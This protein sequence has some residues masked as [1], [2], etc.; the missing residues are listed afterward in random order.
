M[1]PQVTKVVRPASASS[2]QPNSAR[3]TGG[4]LKVRKGPGS[5]GN[6]G[7]TLRINKN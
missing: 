6:Q 5:G 4:V 1:V 2:N 7:K 3:G